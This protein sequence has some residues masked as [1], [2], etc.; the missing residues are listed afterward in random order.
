MTDY[1]LEKIALTLP[2]DIIVNLELNGFKHE[3]QVYNNI[4]KYYNKGE[5]TN[6]P[7]S[8]KK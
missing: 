8:L 7:I 1:V 5:H 6:L 2:Q 4:I 3:S